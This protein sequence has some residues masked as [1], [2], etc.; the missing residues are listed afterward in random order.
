MVTRSKG[1]S[2]A[3]RSNEVPTRQSI[4]RPAA[5][6]ALRAVS[7]MAASASMPIVVPA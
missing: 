1:A 6:A 5:S 4:A 2:D 3:S 7:I